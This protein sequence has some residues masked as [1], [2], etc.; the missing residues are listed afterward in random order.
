MAHLSAKPPSQVKDAMNFKNCLRLT[1]AISFLNVALPSAVRAQDPADEAAGIAILQSAASPHDKDAACH[2]LKRHGTAQSVPALAALLTDPDLAQSARYALESMQVPEAGQA[3]I[4]ALGQTSGPL[5]AGVV[6]SLAVRHETAAV[7]ELAKLLT[8]SDRLV[9]K[10][11][12]QALGDIATPDAVQA[13]TALQLL[14]GPS[15][16]AGGADPE[17]V[18]DACLRAG[19]HLQKAGNL[20]SA[21]AVYQQI[22]QSHTKEF[23]H[24]AAFRGMVL[25]DR[26]HGLDL[27]ASAITNGPA[28]I[29]MA[30]IQ[31]IHEPE[32]ADVTV[33]AAAL[34]PSVDGF[35][36]VALLDALGQRDDP[37]AAPAIAALV[38]QVQGDSRVAA[39]SALGI[40]GDE[41]NVSLLVGIAADSNDPGQAAAR[42]ALVALH[43][44]A[45]NQALI[46]A[47]AGAKPDTQ[48]EIV[49]ALDDRSAAESIPQLLQLAR[50]SE[51]P[52]R[53]AVFKA[54]A[55]LV[56]QPQLAAFV[57]VVAGMTTDDGRTAAASA[58]SLACRHIQARHG[59]VD[60]TPVLEILKNGTAA[61]RVTLLP[62]CSSVADEQV[63]EVLRASLADADPAVHAAAARALCHSA[64]PLL[65]PDVAKIAVESADG[66]LKSLAIEA[67]GRLAAP[68][69][70]APMSV[71]DRLKLYQTILPAASSAADKRLAL[72]G[73]ASLTDP[74]AL[75][76]VLPML[77]NADVR[78]EA[79]LAVIG[80]CG[81]LADADAAKA[82]LQSVLAANPGDQARMQAQA[83]LK[84][85]EVRAEYL[86]VWQYAG[87]YREKGKD[88]SALFDTVFPPETATAS[89]EKWRNLAPSTDPATPW[90]LDLLKAMGGDQE[91]AYARSA[92][93]SPSEQSVQLGIRSDDG[94]K[95]WLN[96]QVVHANNTQRAVTSPPDMVKVTLKAGWNTLL[97][98]VTQNNQGWGFAVHVTTPDGAK[99]A[100]L[101]CAAT[102]PAGAM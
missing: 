63:R 51:D 41:K 81:G 57:Q 79:A 102:A 46:D 43:R 44:G 13:L 52:V 101:Q 5:K 1:L 85:F 25:A 93:Y 15:G 82:A 37:A 76:L 16:T 32:L 54:L 31:L 47:L 14:L 96:G 22:Y 50:Q 75:N 56:D 8:D 98:K 69:A 27:L 33:P 80:I 84:E 9:A 12:A 7:P 3:L 72:S 92:V 39:I 21:L 58:L 45:V 100:G 60:L 11:S 83:L 86:M 88:F 40:L 28:P 38:G 35:A 17:A 19:Q 78:N 91:V 66:E 68:D 49:R 2:W 90:A 64:D 26:A 59:S 4:A 70:D 23:Y 94:I 34:L 89:G 30:A 6:N 61:A 36:Q 99:I 42:Q 29:Q 74:G 97:V 67:C 95:V 71:F 18:V 48:V 62:V 20:D 10:A 73:I 77:G 53:P 55:R 24:V 65:A 87:P